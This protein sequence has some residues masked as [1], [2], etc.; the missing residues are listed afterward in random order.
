V[1]LA[2]L[3]TV[4]LIVV[5]ALA[6]LYDRFGQLSGIEALL[7]GLGAAAGGLVVATGLKMAAPLL[8]QPRALA[9]LAV[10]VGAIALLRWPLVPVLLGVGALSV[11]AAWRRA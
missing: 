10:T 1:A 9:F 2:G 8:R 3:F 5:L 11:L 6:A 7:R 4:P